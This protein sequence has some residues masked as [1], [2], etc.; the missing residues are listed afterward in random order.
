MRFVKTLGILLI[1]MAVFGGAAFALNLYTGPIIEKNNA[2]AANARL[3]SVMPE[4]DKAYED[5]TATITLPEQYVSEANDK[6]TATVTAVYKETKNNFGYVIEVAWTSEDSHGDEPNVVLVG[7]STDGKII[8][9]NNETYHDT[10]N[11]NIFAKDPAYASSFEGKDSALTDVGVVAGSTHSSES[12]RAAVAHAFEVL[13]INDMVSAGVKTDDQI[14]T[15]MIPAL[16]TGLSS[17]GSLKAE[18]VE[19]SGNII[20]GYKSLNN[21][22]Y[23]FIIK[24]GDATLL[25]V[26]NASGVCKVYDTTGA[27]V[28]ESN[29]AV[30]AEAIAAAGATVDNSAK[31]ETMILSKFPEATEITSV[32]L[33]TMGNVISAST[34]KSGDATYYAFYSAPLTYEDHAME[35]CTI[36]D[37]NGAIA[38]QNIT[39]LVFG[40]SLEYV[41]VIKDYVDPAGDSF[42]NYLGIFGGLTQDTLTDD[43]LIA[44]A[45]I[46]SSAVK[47]A[48]SEAFIEFNAIKG[49]E[50]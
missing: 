41:P 25:A 9:V 13:I 31:L 27:D 22:G 21:T 42:N 12:F 6:R 19:V 40:H 10:E 20:A 7:I 36:I 33:T 1:I 39:Q 47:L 44:K 4:G 26:V 38:S 2:G 24:N 11:Y 14:L 50:Q 49:G 5:I 48:T 29:A 17:G 18:A 45:T 32:E 46:S 3:D 16:H 8:K 30:V 23:A 28:T 34:F 37:Q 43:V 35:I 15:E